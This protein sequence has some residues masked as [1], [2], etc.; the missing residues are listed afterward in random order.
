M[1]LLWTVFR[2]PGNTLLVTSFI[3]HDCAE[4][5]LRV[6]IAMAYINGQLS[7]RSEPES[8]GDRPV[9][10]NLPIQLASGSQYRSRVLFL[11]EE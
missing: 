9:F 11:R 2:S 10:E 7:V 3:F 4:P 6:V 5:R 1:L 8:V